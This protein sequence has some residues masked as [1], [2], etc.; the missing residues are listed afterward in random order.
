MRFTQADCDVLQSEIAHPLAQ[1]SQIFRLNVFRDNAAAGADDRGKPYDVV[2]A[3]R[4]DVRD[5]YTGFDAKQTYE[6]V[7]SPAASRSFS[8]C[9]IGLTILATGRSAFGKAAAGAPGSAMKS[10]AE[11]APDIANTVAKTAASAVQY[12]IIVDCRSGPLAAKVPI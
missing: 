12:R 7:G 3:T 5:G 6:L 4:A 10:W 1:T 11:P 2:A 8:S 9:Q